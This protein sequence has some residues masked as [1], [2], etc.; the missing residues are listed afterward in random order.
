MKI[1]RYVV[2]SMPLDVAPMYRIDGQL[3]CDG[4][5]WAVTRGPNDDTAIP[6][7]FIGAEVKVSYR[8]NADEKSALDETLVRVPFAGAK[9]L[10]LD[11]IAVRNRAS[12]APDVA[13]AV[14]LEG[15]VEAFVERS[16]LA[17][18]L[19]L[20]AKLADLQKPD[21]AAFLT[22][23]YNALN[24]KPEACAPTLVEV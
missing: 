3:T 11:P 5:S 22:E 14:T 17:W 19:S 15:K 20:A 23:I 6:E 9:R 10:E 12:R 2:H 16:E 24:H 13:A 8:F 18:S 7:S 21:S 4:F 1:W